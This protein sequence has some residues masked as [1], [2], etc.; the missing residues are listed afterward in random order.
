MVAAGGQRRAGLDGRPRC[1]GGRGNRLTL[2]PQ[3]PEFKTSVKSQSLNPT[4]NQTFQFPLPEADL[5]RTETDL[6]L[7]VFDH[8]KLKKDDLIGAIIFPLMFLDLSSEVIYNCFI[9]QDDPK[10]H[11]MSRLDAARLNLMISEQSSTIADLQ[12]RLVPALQLYFLRQV[13]F[14]IVSLTGP[15]QKGLGADQQ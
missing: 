6:V 11:G 2:R 7:K 3:G 10:T 14:H 15:L 9:V 12:L 8:D 1:P 4:F 5:A 13:F